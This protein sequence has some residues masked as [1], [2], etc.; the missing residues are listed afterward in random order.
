M[1]DAVI[2]NLLDARQRRLTS[3]DGLITQRSAIVHDWFQGMHGAERTVAAMFDLF[4]HEPDIFTFQAARE[5]LPDRIADA[6]VSESRLA[7]LPGRAPARP[8]ARPVALAVALHAP[9]LR[10]A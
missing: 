10:A 6:I 5:L 3:D 4:S 2:G 7:G 1:T 8:R 9:L